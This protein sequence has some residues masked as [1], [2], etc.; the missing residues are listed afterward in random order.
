MSITT[1][2]I[3]AAA[4]CFVLGLVADVVV[5]SYK[6]GNALIILAIALMLA[7][8]FTVEAPEHMRD[9]DSLP[10]VPRELRD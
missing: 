5:D 2:L 6:P 3:I 10:A 9:S 1:Y 8:F 4:A 7:A